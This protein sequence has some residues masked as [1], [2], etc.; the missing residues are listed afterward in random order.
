MQRRMTN[1]SSRRWVACLHGRSPGRHVLPYACTFRFD[2]AYIQEN[3]E[4]YGSR[5]LIQAGLQLTESGSAFPVY[6]LQAVTGSIVSYPGREY[7]VLKEVASQ[8]N[9]TE[10][11]L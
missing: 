6:P 9:I 3:T 8:T 7:W 10:K 5:R 2:S 1:R 4:V 11:L